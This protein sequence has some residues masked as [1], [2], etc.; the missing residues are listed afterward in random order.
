MI[1]DFI[2]LGEV[3]HQ[4]EGVNT[5]ANLAVT[6][7]VEEVTFKLGSDRKCFPHFQH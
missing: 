5:F 2:V 1:Y 3:L 6:S 7:T 4:L